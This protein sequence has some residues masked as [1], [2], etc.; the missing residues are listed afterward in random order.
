MVKARLGQGVD[1]R[2]DGGIYKK[3]VAETQKISQAPG[4]FEP[5]GVGIF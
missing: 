4:L 2:M 5:G 3:M 1:C